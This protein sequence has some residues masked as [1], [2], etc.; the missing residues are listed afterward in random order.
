MVYRHGVVAGL[1]VH[2]TLGDQTMPVCFQ[3]SLTT[4]I[5]I[6][7]EAVSVSLFPQPGQIRP[8]SE[9][10]SCDFPD[11]Q[12]FSG[13]CQSDILLFKM[14]IFMSVAHLQNYE[15]VQNPCGFYMVS[16]F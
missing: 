8:S 7:S 6:V 9:S 14:S 16:S 10:A 3:V 11:G 5:P 1:W 15:Y 2:R 4:R 12:L 13:I